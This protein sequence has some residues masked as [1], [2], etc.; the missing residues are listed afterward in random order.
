MIIIFDLDDTL[1][2]EI[3]YVKSGFEEV[4]KFLNKN[5]SIN[6]NDSFDFMMNFLNKNGRG[7]IFNSILKQYGIYNK[8]NLMSCISTYRKHKPKIYMS[9]DIIN[10]L[11][12]LGKK[13]P[14][15]LVTDGNK[16]VQKNKVDS[17]NIEY[18]FKKIF[19]THRY[20]INNA[21]PSLY[22]FNIIK[23]MENCNWSD[24]V[25]VGDN[26]KK[27]FVNLNKVGAK[28]VRILNGSFKNLKA[29]EGYDAIF[30]YKNIINFL[31][32]Y[33]KI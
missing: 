25:Y 16:I 3:N 26:P 27:D 5:F 7:R 9:K 28:T 18:L 2:D 20:G 14:L 15:Y 19:I 10:L 6:K 12:K 21:K 31:I 22:C 30:C 1:Y 4:S 29:K 23:K 8:K 24:I 33:E 17:L 13:N 32:D 11:L